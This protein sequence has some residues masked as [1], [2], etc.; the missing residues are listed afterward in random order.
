MRN[1]YDFVIIRFNH[2]DKFN[3]F[4]MRHFH[5]AIKFFF[6]VNT[7]TN[8]IKPYINT[9]F[10]QH[11]FCLI[12]QWNILL[13]LSVVSLCHLIQELSTSLYIMTVQIKRRLG[14]SRKIER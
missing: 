1:N 14:N 6:S 4:K 7:K 10:F 13:D 11:K 3:S 5:K 2:E 9:C 8:A 12:S